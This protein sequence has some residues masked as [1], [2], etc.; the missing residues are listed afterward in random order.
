LFDHFVS[1]AKQTQI[2]PAPRDSKDI[3]IEGDSKDI[4]IEGD[5][6]DI[7]IEGDKKMSG[8]FRP[9]YTLDSKD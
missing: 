7:S 4:S 6:K 9:L 8:Q 2:M 5:S 3:S 1:K